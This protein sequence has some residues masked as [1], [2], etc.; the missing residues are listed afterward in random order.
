[1]IPRASRRRL[2]AA[3]LV[4]AATIPAAPTAA[5]GPPEVTGLIATIKGPGARGGAF[6]DYTDDAS[7]SANVLVLGLTPGATYRV[8]GTVTACAG[9]FD[10]SDRVFGRMIEALG[11]GSAR[12]AGVTL[13]R[14]STADAVAVRVLRGPS[15]GDQVGCGRGRGLV[16]DP[17]PFSS[18]PVIVSPWNGAGPKGLVFARQTGDERTDLTVALKGLDGDGARV[19]GT[20]LAC[21]D[22]YDGAAAYLRPA[23]T[24]VNAK[25]HAFRSG[26][27]D[28][29]DGA[30]LFDVDTI[31]VGPGSGPFAPAA[32]RARQA[33]YELTGA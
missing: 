12:L 5:I 13:A 28:L 4:A 31:W 26:R 30:K 20:G 25:G 10:P 21:V 14:A 18:N 8:V 1:V 6:M 17:G 24:P 27:A 15:G 9:A 2:S 11:D 22:P 7:M 19:R 33:W 32:C 16:E 23:V 29:T 3:I